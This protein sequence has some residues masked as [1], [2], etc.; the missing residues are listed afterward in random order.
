MFLMRLEESKQ[1]LSHYFVIPFN[2][3]NFLKLH[4]FYFA[5]YEIYETIQDY[6]NVSEY[7][8]NG[9]KIAQGGK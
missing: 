6:E 5:N 7:N 2:N 1:G 9:T 8:K 4:Q 3:L